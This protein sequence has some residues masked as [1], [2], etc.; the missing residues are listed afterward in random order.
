MGF[1]RGFRLGETV[2]DPFEQLLEEIFGP[3]RRTIGKRNGNVA[4]GRCCKRFHGVART[5]QYGVDFDH[6]QT[7]AKP[8][9]C[10]FMRA[11]LGDKGC[12]F[13]AHVQVFNADSV[14]VAGENAPIYGKDTKTA[15]P[16]VSYDGCKTWD[17]YLGG[18]RPNPKPKSVRVFWVK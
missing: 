13:K 16:I 8:N 9:D 12:G 4:R 6:V 17:W 10:D 14:L 1:G 11:P 7:D 5:V 15:R 3:E 18:T 2:V